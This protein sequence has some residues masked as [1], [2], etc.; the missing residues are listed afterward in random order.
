MCSL[1]PTRLVGREG[2]RRRTSSWRS[3]RLSIGHN[4]PFHCVKLHD[5]LT[6]NLPYSVKHASNLLHG[7]VRVNSFGEQFSNVTGLQRLI[8]HCI[9]CIHAGILGTT[10]FQLLSFVS[11]TGF[12][13][14]ITLYRK[15]HH[16][17]NYLTE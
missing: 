4:L 8:R 16:F 5:E 7:I 9:H 13:G 15:S 2:A 3:G 14:E 12:V 10:I 11:G 17:C 6:N 1:L